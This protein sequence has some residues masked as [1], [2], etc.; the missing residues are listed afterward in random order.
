MRSEPGLAEIDGL[1]EYQPVTN[2]K[3]RT[4]NYV[5]VGCGQ[6]LKWWRELFSVLRMTGYDGD[7]SLEMEGLT[8][9]VEAGLQTSIDAL[10]MTICR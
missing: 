6:D 1:M 2:T 4:R 9:G 7:V 3:T 8:M 10:N 5:A